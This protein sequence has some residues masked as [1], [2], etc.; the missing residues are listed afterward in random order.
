[1]LH[2]ITSLIFPPWKKKEFFLKGN[3]FIFH[4]NST[5]VVEEEKRKEKERAK[6]Q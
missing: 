1:V 2:T 3:I 6:E 5:N 4:A